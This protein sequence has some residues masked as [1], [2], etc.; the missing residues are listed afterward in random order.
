MY[1]KT[2]QL[3]KIS[4]KNLQFSI[5]QFVKPHKLAVLAFPDKLKIVIT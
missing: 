2:P 1:E 3:R 4:K 5:L